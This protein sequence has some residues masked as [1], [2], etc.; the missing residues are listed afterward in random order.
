MLP[1]IKNDGE[2]LSISRVLFMDMNGEPMC[3]Y[4]RPGPAKVELQAHIK[5]GGGLVC[6][7]QQPGAILLADPEDMEAQVETTAHRYVSTQYIRDCIEGNVQLDVDDYHINPEHVQKRCTRQNPS[8]QG[9]SSLLQGR[10]AYTPEED[11]AILS[12]VAKHKG[13]TGGNLFWKEMSKNNVTSHSWQSM[14]YRYAKKLAHR[15][16]EVEEKGCKQEEPMVV[17]NQETCVLNPSP[18][19]HALPPQ[20]SSSSDEAAVTDSSQAN[21]QPIPAESSQPEAVEPAQDRSLPNTRWQKKQLASPQP[22]PA[23]TRSTCRQLTLEELTS[24]QPSR[25]K[26]R[27]S[28]PSPPQKATSSPQPMKKTESTDKPDLQEAESMDQTSPEEDRGERGLIVAEN[29]QEETEQA[30][31]SG[32]AAKTVAQKEGKKKEK[33]KLGILEMAT[34]EF[35]D[36]IESD[37]EETPDLKETTD[38]QKP[39]KTAER[40]NQPTETPASSAATAPKPGSDPESNLQENKLEV[41]ASGGQPEAACP[42]PAPSEPGPAPAPAPAPAPGPSTSKPHLFIFESESQEE[43]S[44]SVITC[45]RP[46][47]SEPTPAPAPASN[48]TS[49]S[50]PASASA[51]APAPTPALAPAPA[52]NPTPALAPAPASNPTPALAPAPTPALAPGPGPGPGPFASKPHRFIFESESQESKSV[53]VAG[54]SAPQPITSTDATVSLTQVQLEEDKRRIVQL[55]KETNQDLVSVTKALLKTSGDFS[56]ALRLLLTPSS[57]PGPFWNRKDDGLLLS[58]DTTVRQQLQEKYGETGL[59]KR[60]V[61][62]EVE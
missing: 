54:P 22:A 16:P 34:K 21:A 35:E 27:L 1:K 36:D 3:F 45:P 40:R 9:S 5:A 14:K 29:E 32:E 2:P 12:Y 17:E 25:K 4:L 10:S 58:A 44:Q 37:N 62:L 55:M 6:R 46:V 50:A 18:E 15:Q 51:L 42:G 56:A 43:E 26:A 28:A 61:F 33:R 24:A 20:T 38:V 59:A 30:S 41:R 57:V 23:R 52:S 11:A 49:A 31:T 7:T 13:E 47:P 39:E 60:L 19:E 53:S 48:P 8:K